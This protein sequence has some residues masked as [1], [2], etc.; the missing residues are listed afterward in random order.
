MMIIMNV[1]SQSVI[2][3]APVTI[4]TGRLTVPVHQVTRD[5]IVKST[6]TTVSLTHVKTGAPVTIRLTTTHVYVLEVLV[7]FTVRMIS[8]SVQVTHV[9]MERFVRTTST[10]IR[11]HVDLDIVAKI[12]RTMIMIAQLRKY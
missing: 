5:N 9:K 1:H 11:V 3:E 2:T 12:V 4:S 7:V 6:T 10:H 8:T